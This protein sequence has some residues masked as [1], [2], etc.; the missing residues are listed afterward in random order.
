MKIVELLEAGT[1]PSSTM[2][3]GMIDWI[4]MLPAISG[5]GVELP[6]WVQTAW[7]WPVFSWWTGAAPPCLMV[8]A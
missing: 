4:V 1:T 2:S 6:P 3:S 7:K 5:F 8:D